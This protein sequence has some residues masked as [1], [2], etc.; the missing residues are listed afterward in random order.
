MKNSGDFEYDDLQGLVRFGYGKLL[1]ET[2][3]LLLNIVDA[4]A[5]KHDPVDVRPGAWH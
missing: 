5:A 4:A 3:F 1:P 2:C